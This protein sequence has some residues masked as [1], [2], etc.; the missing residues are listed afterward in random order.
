C[1]KVQLCSTSSSS[2]GVESSKPSELLW[3]SVCDA[4]GGSAAGRH[5]AAGAGDLSGSAGTGAVVVRGLLLGAAATGEDAEASRACIPP[6]RRL[7][8]GR[9][10][11]SSSRGHL[12]T[13]C[14]RRGVA[15]AALGSRDRTRTQQASRSGSS[16]DRGERKEDPVGR[17]AR[18]N[19]GP[20]EGT[21]DEAPVESHPGISNHRMTR[22]PRTLRAEEDGVGGRRRMQQSTVR[23]ETRLN[24]G[25]AAER[26]DTGGQ[27]RPQEDWG[28]RAGEDSGR[29][30]DVAQASPAED[31][32]VTRVT[33]RRGEKTAVGGR[34]CRLCPNPNPD[35]VP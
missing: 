35:G 34:E 14:A 8:V 5:W 21:E 28:R 30:S 32:F 16:G 4:G 24:F 2:R 10:D 33:R 26:S 23:N 1:Q 20:A 27:A 9:P 19:H 7:L 22:R 3:S 31:A 12:P 29:G 6:R 25:R 13:G 15:P 17:A 18:Y 11:D